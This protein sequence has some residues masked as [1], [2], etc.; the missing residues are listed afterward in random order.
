LAACKKKD[1]PIV[2]EDVDFLY[3]LTNVYNVLSIENITE[4][5]AKPTTRNMNAIYN[6]GKMAQD[7][8]EGEVKTLVKHLQTVKDLGVGF[9]GQDTIYF[10]NYLPAGSAILHGCG[11]VPVKYEILRL[12]AEIDARIA[13][14]V[15]EENKIGSGVYEWYWRIFVAAIDALQWPALRATDTMLVQS[16]INLQFFLIHFCPRAHLN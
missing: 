9:K 12:I 15:A 1:E 8:K 10:S 16:I 13:E 2:K 4:T 5:K 14:L 11:I 3:N 6:G 7:W